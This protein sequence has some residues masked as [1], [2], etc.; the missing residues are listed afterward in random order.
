MAQSLADCLAQVA[1]AGAASAAQLTAL[2][3]ERDALR[4]QLAT[5][6]DERDSLRGQLAGASREELQAL[7]GARDKQLA[8]Q[9]KQIAV[10][11]AALA[12]ASAALA[13]ASAE[14]ATA[15]AAAAAAA[16]VNR[17]ALRAERALT[18]A[19]LARDATL[20]AALYGIA[21][22]RRKLARPSVRGVLLGEGLLDTVG[23]VSAMGYA[24]DVSHCRELCRLTWRVVQRGDT[25][26][27][28][29]RS[30]EL[31]CGAKAARA[32]KREDFLHPRNGKVLGTTQLIRAALLNNLPRVRQLIQLGAPLGLVDTPQGGGDSA[33][34][35][36]SHE[37]HEQVIETLLDGKFEGKGAAIEQR[38][39][40]GVTPLICVS[41]RG[42]EGSVRVLLAR[43][44]RQVL[45]R[46]CGST[47]LHNAARYGHAGV[48]ALLCAAPGAAVALALKTNGKD[49]ETPLAIAIKN[50]HAATEAVLRAHG[51]KA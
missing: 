6:T 17:E 43:G 36:A 29:E 39:P 2:A 12:S 33:L 49:G 9:E 35:W 8:E 21:D 48:A 5:V 18:G 3:A 38:G 47:A 15:T 13:S 4:D 45:Q 51:A 16:E 11:D 22:L 27:M 37:G 25:A 44:A 42:N 34:H 40:S 41:I 24:A 31:Q 20:S 32:T 50:H 7:D 26:S 23:I 10:R 14:R 28:L 19:V 30:L 46:S 1:A